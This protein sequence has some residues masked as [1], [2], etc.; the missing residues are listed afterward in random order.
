MGLI[1]KLYVSSPTGPEF[2]L[3]ELD[4][5]APFDLLLHRIVARL[6]PSRISKTPV[7]QAPN[8]DAELQ[9]V[10]DGICICDTMGDWITVTCEEEWELYLKSCVPSVPEEEQESFILNVQVRP[11]V[12]YSQVP[13]KPTTIRRIG[14]ALKSIFISSAA[15]K[16]AKPVEVAETSQ[17]QQI[18]SHDQ[19]EQASS[20]N[21]DDAS[22][23]TAI[24]HSSPVPDPLAVPTLQGGDSV[25]EPP[26]EATFEIINDR[27]EESDMEDEED[28]EDEEEEE[29]EKE[30]EEE[31]IPASPAPEVVVPPEFQDVWEVLVQMGFTDNKKMLQLLTRYKGKN[32]ARIVDQLL[33]E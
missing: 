31:E 21:T 2:C 4:R 15:T 29:D 32:L 8:E 7:G 11:A 22:V 9:P 30:E 10:K 24:Q 19:D 28:E 25:E 1:I 16:P 14:S 3:F 17:Q 20:V 23:L 26:D 18:A 12:G 5:D 33:R 6:P 13:N 27:E